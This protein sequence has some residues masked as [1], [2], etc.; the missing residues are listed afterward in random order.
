MEFEIEN[1]VLNRYTGENE[2]VVIPEDVKEINYYAFSMRSITEVVIPE[3]VTAIRDNAFCNCKQLQRVVLPNTLLSIGRE[4]FAECTQLES[5]NFPDQLNKIDDNAFRGCTS[6]KEVNIKSPLSVLIGFKDCTALSRIELPEGLTEI[7]SGAFTSC[8]SISSVII[9]STVKRICSSAFSNCEN[10]REITIPDGM[11]SIDGSAFMNCANLSKICVPAETDISM[12][13]P[14]RGCKSLAD[15]NGFVII[16]GILFYYCGQSETVVVPRTVNKIADNAFGWD[17]NIISATIP[18]S[19]TEIGR[20]IFI[21]C[22]RLKK[23]EL[24]NSLEK[25]E[26]LFDQCS[27]LTNVVIPESIIYI[28][29]VPFSR[30]NQL[31]K[32]FLPAKVSLSG[33]KGTQLTYDQTIFF[34]FT[35][36]GEIVRGLA[37]CEKKDNNN[38][39]PFYNSAGVFIDNE[40]TWNKYDEGIINNGPKFKFKDDLRIRAAIWRLMRPQYL[41][42]EWKNKYIEYLIKNAKKIVAIAEE[43]EMPEYIAIIL[44]EGIVNEKNKKAVLPLIAGSSNVEIAKLA[45]ES[46]K[47]V[48]K[49]SKTTK[50]DNEFNPNKWQ[51]VDKNTFA[52]AGGMSPQG[53]QYEYIQSRFRGYEQEI[54]KLK[55][56]LDS[57]PQD[58]ECFEVK[59]GVYE[60][61]LS[62]DANTADLIEKFPTLKATGLREDFKNSVVDVWLSLSG[63]PVINECE[64]AGYFDGEYEDGDA[65]WEFE[66]DMMERVRCKFEHS[67]MEETVSV[68]YSYPS[69]FKKLWNDSEYVLEQQGKYYKK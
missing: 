48:A 54:K 16:N 66:Y 10:L 14:F 58:Y 41:K 51:E 37:Y 23:V 65:R 59:N 39:E 36:N 17:T 11:S 9:P 45:P 33:Y 46:M 20:N 53:K 13:N 55:S 27:S 29:G 57:I 18:E 12:R 31:K 67:A 63:Y 60:L 44:S 19:V 42:E 15:D 38:F 69:D 49:K 26:G 43:D 62:M 4:A 25:V 7:G 34:F 47:E 50:D 56:H 61:R 1:G 21:A 40:F 52:A 64:E 6:L 24:P 28:F 8:K 30:C 35:E 2:T 22:S 3:G 32:V 68:D 5:I